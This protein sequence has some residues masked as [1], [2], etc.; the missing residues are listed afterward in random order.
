MICVLGTHRVFPDLAARPYTEFVDPA[1]DDASFADTAQFLAQV[2]SCG[3]G[4]L[5]VRDLRIGSAPVADFRDA[6]NRD[7]RARRGGDAG[8]GRC[9][10]P[11][12]AAISPGTPKAR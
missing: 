7:Q 3:I 12:P 11:S 9:E 5:T 4:D 10:R 2:Y 8:R 6:D 1:P